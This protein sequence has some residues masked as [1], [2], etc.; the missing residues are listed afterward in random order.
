[1]VG[2]VDGVLEYLCEGGANGV[3][4]SFGSI[5]CFPLSTGYLLS[6]ISEGSIRDDKIFT[7]TF[8]D[9]EINV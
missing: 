3:N 4:F 2:I 6:R 1:M 5:L 8:G 9:T 7:H